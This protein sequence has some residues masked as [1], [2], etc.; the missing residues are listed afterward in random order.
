MTIKPLVEPLFTY[1]FIRM[2]LKPVSSSLPFC[3]LNMNRRQEQCSAVHSETV[4]TPVLPGQITSPDTS[5]VGPASPVN[6]ISYLHIF[7]LKE[8]KL[9]TRAQT[10]MSS[11]WLQRQTRPVMLRGKDVYYQGHCTGHKP[12]VLSGQSSMMNK[13]LLFLQYLHILWISKPTHTQCT[14]PVTQLK[15]VIWLITG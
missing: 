14:R 12:R 11:A 10:D 5:A 2:A 7:D 13:L 3:L 9:K 15:L 1:I 8:K 4:M 6:L